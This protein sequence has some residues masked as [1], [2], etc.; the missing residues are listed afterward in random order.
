[1]TV[2]SSSSPRAIAAKFSSTAKDSPLFRAPLT[3]HMRRLACGDGSVYRSKFGGN[4][5]DGQVGPLRILRSVG[6]F[7]TPR[8]DGRG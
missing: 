4:D 1:M 8:C 5:P 3:P 6:G 7:V 2:H